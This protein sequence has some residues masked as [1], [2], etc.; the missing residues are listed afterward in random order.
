M[1]YLA[2]QT[3]ELWSVANSSKIL[4]YLEPQSDVE[5]KLIAEGLDPTEILVEA[6]AE[7]FF[8]TVL[9]ALQSETG[10]VQDSLAEFQQRYESEQLNKRMDGFSS[11]L[12]KVA[13]HVGAIGR[14]IDRQNAER[15]EQ[16]EAE[17]LQ[18]EREAE[19]APV[20]EEYNTLSA[21]LKTLEAWLKG[22][23]ST[24]RTK[25]KFGQKISMNDLAGTKQYIRA[26]A[27]RKRM[28]EL[29]EQLA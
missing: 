6:P 28:A 7:Q 14:E 22:Q 13:D 9:A 3:N 27:I 26:N 16:V 12:S 17:R 11:T 24:L 1:T 15:A 25:S 2:H 5:A 10:S 23:L 21:E 8:P 20:W 4:A 29:E 18:A 19:L